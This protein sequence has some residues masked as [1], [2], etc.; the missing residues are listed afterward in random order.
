M[1][2]EYVFLASYVGKVLHGH[3][4]K[5]EASLLVR[6]GIHHAGK[7]RGIRHAMS[8]IAPNWHGDGIKEFSAKDS[9]IDMLSI[10]GSLPVCWDDI[11]KHTGALKTI[12]E[13]I[14]PM[15]NSTAISTDSGTI[16]P[17]TLPCYTAN[18]EE[19]RELLAVNTA[20][21]G[22]MCIMKVNKPAKVISHNNLRLERAMKGASKGLGLLIGIKVNEGGCEKLADRLETLEPG[23]DSRVY[24]DLALNWWYSDK[25]AELLGS[26]KSR[27]AQLKKC[28]E[29]YITTHMLA[30]SVEY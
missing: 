22:R 25:A 21:P 8:L 27:V 12:S 20:L 28:V 23:L 19:L 26:N 9:Q 3:K 11:K 17:C 30:A 14:I 7:T 13:T 5:S 29:D 10:L 6:V 2:G 24:K 18:D 1:L 15:H 16:Q 4:H